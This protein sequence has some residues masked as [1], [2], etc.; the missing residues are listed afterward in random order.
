[1]TANYQQSFVA[2]P[3]NLSEPI[4]FDVLPDGSGRV[5]QTDRRGGVR[6]HDP[7]S[8]S[9]TL[10][11]QLPVYIA[12]EDGMYG[13]E[14]DNNFNTNKWVY[15]YY[16]PPTVEDVRFADGTLHTVTTPL[17]D[18]ATPQNEQNAPNFAASLSAWDQYNGYF[19][20]SRFKFVD[21]TASEPAHLDLA[22]RAA[23]P[24]R[25]QQPRRVLPRRRRHRLRLEEQPV[26]GHG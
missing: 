9:T 23:D 22:S 19:Q 26:D 10:L 2:A 6:L 17:N 7:V 25:A 16:S 15:L 11:A 20:L 24:A 8:N 5:I 21:A 4:G 12:N 14:V 18:P 1:M 13:P 3:P